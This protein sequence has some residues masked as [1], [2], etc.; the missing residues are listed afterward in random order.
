M[1]REQAS[2]TSLCAVTVGKKNF[3][4]TAEMYIS[5]G[6]MNMNLKTKLHEE[7]AEEEEKKKREPSTCLVQSDK[8]ALQ[9]GRLH[10]NAT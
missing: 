4:E 5:K 8:E 9:P 7:E 3:C 1:S 2:S 6:D 10:G